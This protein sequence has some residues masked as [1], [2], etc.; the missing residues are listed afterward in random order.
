M[1]ERTPGSN[2][3]SMRAWR[4]TRNRYGRAVYERFKRVG[5]TATWLTEY[6]RNVDGCVSPRTHPD[7]SVGIVDPPAVSPLDAPVGELRPG[8]EVLAA[9]ESGSPRGYL[10]LSVDATHEIAPLERTLSFE[11]AYVRRVFVALDH[12]DRGIAS[13]LLAT[14]R[15]RVRARGAGRA[16]ALVARDNVP[17][18]A[19]FASQGFV[20]V[21]ERLYLRLGPLSGRWVRESDRGP[22]S[23]GIRETPDDEP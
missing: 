7:C 12:R 17:S 16:T 11:G 10:F 5:V 4:V 22:Q 19:L 9:T 20:P 15:D 14:A 18:R 21:R 23:G 1:C 8:E 3:T 6:V 2:T 13:A